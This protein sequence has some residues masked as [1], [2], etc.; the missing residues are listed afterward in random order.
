MRLGVDRIIKVA[1]VIAVD[2]HKWQLTQIDARSG[3]TWIDTLAEDLSLAQ[4]V[5]RKLVRQ[6]EARDGGLG[7]QLHRTIGIED[8]LDPRLRGGGGAGVADDARN[9]PVTVT[10]TVQVRR[11]HRTSQL[12]APV[13]GIHPGTASLNLDRA[14]KGAD[15]ARENLFDT[16]R[17]TIAPIAGDSDTQPIAVHHAAHLGRWQENTFAHTFHAQKT[18]A[19]TIGT[20]RAFDNRTR[21]KRGISATRA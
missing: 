10:G 14:E 20:D 11:R 15:T 18:V 12:Q 2:G 7:G 6:I 21:S 19:G 3:L 13:G 1:R 8:L 5:C 4:R 9:R 16:P 17:P